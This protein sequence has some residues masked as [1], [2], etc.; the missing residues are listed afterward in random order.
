MAPFGFQA[1]CGAGPSSPLS[2]TGLL[3]ESRLGIVILNEG[4]GIF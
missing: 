1:T 3:Q 2:D 4:L